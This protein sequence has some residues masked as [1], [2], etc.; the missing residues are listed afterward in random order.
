VHERLLT[1]HFLHRFVDNDLIS[2]DADRHEVLS[3]TAAVLVSGT[4]FATVLLSAKYLFLPFPSPARVAFLAV[5]DRFFFVTL[6]MAVMGLAAVAVW[7]ALVLDARD[8]EILGSLPVPRRSLVVAKSAA[9]L[10]LAA[11]VV[12]AVTAVPTVVHPIVMAGRLQ[13]GLGGLVTLSIGH[14]AVT[15]LAGASTFM[16]VL[17]VREISRAVLG[18][19]LFAQVSG[20]LQGLLLIAFATTLLV[21]PAL[22][23]AVVY[24]ALVV[25]PS[26]LYF[27][28]PA[29]FVGLLEATTAG[30]IA[31]LP[32]GDL[33][34]TIFALEQRASVLYQSVRPLLIPLAPLAVGAVASVVAVGPAAYLWNASRSPVSPATVTTTP[35]TRYAAAARWAV[36]RVVV[37]RSVAQAGFFFTLQCLWRSLPHR[38]SLGAAGAVGIAVSVVGL[39]AAG[40]VRDELTG[41]AVASVFAAQTLMLIAL[42]LGVRHAAR[43]P[44]A[45]PAS[46]V[47]RLAFSGDHHSYRTGVRRAVTVGLCTPV[48]LALFV[49]SMGLMELHAAVVHFLSGVLLALILFELV[50]LGMITLPF[51]SGFMPSGKLKSVA[52]IV[53]LTSI[54]GAYSLAW[55]EQR[56]LVDQRR[57]A[58]LLIV[59]ALLYAAV[60]AIARWLAGD[61]EP[62]AAA[63]TSDDASLS[64]VQRFDLNK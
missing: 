3:V 30:M 55:V 64:Q 41:K 24:R 58:V 49:W 33:P 35:R 14:A 8:N 2:P 32:Y 20:P 18:E 28:P 13:I 21:V 60:R 12:I 25:D 26:L 5:Q 54:L 16:A 7:N 15:A 4:L 62:H 53:V 27:I 31:D 51:V 6:T 17:A 1:G 34:P 39:Y 57:A 10:L 19:R 48:L 37:R 44:A 9:V 45:L 47:F 29:W 43:L 50:W 40:G 59:L 42:L 46:W 56:A 38:L 11:G 61:R 52:P 63:L 22:P 23:A 36:Q